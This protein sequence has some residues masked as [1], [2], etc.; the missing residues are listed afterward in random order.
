M[1][2]WGTKL[3]PGVSS[4]CMPFFFYLKQNPYFPLF[5][6]SFYKASKSSLDQ[7]SIS[8]FS[9]RSR[10]LG[11]DVKGCVAYTI[12]WK[13]LVLGGVWLTLQ[14]LATN[15]TSQSFASRPA[16]RI[17]FVVT[18]CSSYQPCHCPSFLIP[19][20]LSPLIPC[21]NLVAALG[22]STTRARVQAE[23]LLP[24]AHMFNF[25]GST[26]T[27]DPGSKFLDT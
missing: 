19:V 20:L 7:L 4:L 6:F 26:S 9:Q 8:A 5:F 3:S 10:A 25:P 24:G 12:R 18:L 21:I 22:V 16:S 14:A 15:K 11:L 17:N 27:S 1:T 23:T 2:I 13:N